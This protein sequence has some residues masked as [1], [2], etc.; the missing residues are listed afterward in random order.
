M[1]TWASLAWGHRDAVTELLLLLT[2]SQVEPSCT[3]LWE[4]LTV[5]LPGCLSA[6]RRKERKGKRYQILDVSVI[7]PRMQPADCQRTCYRG[8]RTD[9][10]PTREWE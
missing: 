4:A 3:L 10:S 1:G 5:T 7:V 8:M 2:G 9:S 6:R